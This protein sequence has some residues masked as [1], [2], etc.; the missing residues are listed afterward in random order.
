MYSPS[1]GVKTSYKFSE[2]KQQQQQQQQQQLQRLPFFE[3]MREEGGFTQLLMKD[4][5][6]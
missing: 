2:I 1:K 6:G 3:D 4:K 5:T